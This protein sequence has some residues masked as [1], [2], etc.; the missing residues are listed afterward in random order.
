MYVK[1]MLLPQLI[2]MYH[3]ITSPIMSSQL[4]F[5]RRSSENQRKGESWSWRHDPCPSLL[6]C[7]GKELALIV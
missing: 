6:S 4:S 3:D 2:C 7:L 5:C 1:P